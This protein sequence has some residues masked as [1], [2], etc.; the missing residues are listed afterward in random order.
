MPRPLSGRGHN[1]SKYFTQ[2]FKIENSNGLSFIIRGCLNVFKRFSGIFKVLKD[3][4][5]IKGS[6]RVFA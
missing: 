6:S 4:N 1:K 5:Q 3:F 2:I